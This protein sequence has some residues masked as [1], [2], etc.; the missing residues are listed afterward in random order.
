[1]FTLAIFIEHG[2]GV[3]AR[4]ERSLQLR[5]KTLLLYIL[6]DADKWNDTL[7]HGLKELILLKCAYYPK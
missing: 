5:H 3:L 6:D 7:C 1:V 4:A 2:L